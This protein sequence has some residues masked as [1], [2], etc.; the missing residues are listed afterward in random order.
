M[1]SSLPRLRL[2][3][4]LGWVWVGVGGCGWVWV[5]VGGCGWVWVGVG[6][7]GGW[8]WAGK[9]HSESEGQGERQ[10]QGEGQGEHEAPCHHRESGQE[11]QTEGLC[12]GA[13]WKDEDGLVKDRV[14]QRKFNSL[15]AG[16]SVAKH[17]DRGAG[18]AGPAAHLGE[19]C[20]RPA[21]ER[22]LGLELGKACL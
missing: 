17:V 16:G 12:A 5:G 11:R 10:G 9:S 22:A 3:R 15:L 6:G 14:K 20:L 19:R 2:V 18:Q 7:C 8:V 21:P 1:N 4:A 13:A